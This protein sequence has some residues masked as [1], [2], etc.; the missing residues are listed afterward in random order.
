MTSANYIYG[1]K[2]LSSSLEIIGQ[3]HIR[4]SSLHTLDLGILSITNIK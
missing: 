3:T 4:P 2:L 1:A